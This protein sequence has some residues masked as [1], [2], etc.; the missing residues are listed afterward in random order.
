[1]NHVQR[2]GMKRAC[3]RF[4]GSDSTNGMRRDGSFTRQAADLIQKT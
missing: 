3:P 4:T 1:M 2:D